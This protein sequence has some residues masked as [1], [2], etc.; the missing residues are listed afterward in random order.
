MLSKVPLWEKFKFNSGEEY[1][2][3]DRIAFDGV[4]HLYVRRA[5]MDGFENHKI[6][7]ANQIVYY[8]LVN[9]HTEKDKIMSTTLKELE[10]GD[11]FTI[12]NPSEIFTKVAEH[13]NLHSMFS[14]SGFMIECKDEQNKRY[15]CASEQIVKKWVKPLTLGELKPGE[16]FQIKDNASLVLTKLSSDKYE[17][18]YWTNSVSYDQSY[19]IHVFDANTHVER[20]IPF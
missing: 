15:Y 12:G 2:L 4:W 6:D 8:P 5:K 11:Q 7:V 20:Y 1:I 3:E 10:K 18:P 19:K 17:Y 9:T 13:H 14:N 16:K